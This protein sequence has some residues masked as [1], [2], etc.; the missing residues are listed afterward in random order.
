MSGE[1]PE[2]YDGWKAEHEGDADDAWYCPGCGLLAVVCLCPPPD[3]RNAFER[4]VDEQ[5]ERERA[6]GGNG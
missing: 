4:A 5:V 2:S 6:E 1:L 3:D